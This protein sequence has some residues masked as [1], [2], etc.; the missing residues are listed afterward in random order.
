M[1]AL[2]ICLLSILISVVCGVRQSYVKS[3]S[4]NYLCYV[5][6]ATNLSIILQIR[7]DYVKIEQVLLLPTYKIIFQQNIM[8]IVIFKVGTYLSR[9]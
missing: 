3:S 6:L 7:N 8:I 4:M 9:I 5:K 2:F 1:F